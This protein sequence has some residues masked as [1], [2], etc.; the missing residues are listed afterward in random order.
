MYNFF[1]IYKVFHIF[2]GIF[3][4]KF[5]KKHIGLSAIFLIFSLCPIIS[6]SQTE[7]NDETKADRLHG[8]YEFGQAASLYKKE[9]EKCTDSLKRIVLEK[10]L[11]Q[12]E[13]G[14]SL[15]EFVFEPVVEAAKQYPR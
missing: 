14:M 13:N 8:K 15:L 9:L 4:R 3:L 7:K 10:K 1:L 11:I 2:V 6:L 12:S 5:M